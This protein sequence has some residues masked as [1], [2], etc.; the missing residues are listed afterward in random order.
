MHSCRSLR[1]QDNL[2]PLSRIMHMLTLV[3]PARR[4]AAF[5]LIELLVVIAIIAILAGMLLPALSKA[6]AKGQGILC[7]NNTRQL[8][9]AWQLYSGDFDDRVANNFGVNET[10]ASIQNGS[11]ANW[12][13][14]VMSWGVEQSVTNVN[15]VRN[16]VL[17]KYTAGA[18]GVYK[19]PADIYL[20]RNQK[21]AGF[22]SRLR[23]LSMNALFGLFSTSPSDPTRSGR[24]ALIPYKQY[25]KQ[26]DVRSPSEVWVTLDEHPNSI[27]DGYFIND[28]GITQWGDLPASYHNGAG[29]FSF[30]D[31]HAEIKKWKSG[32]TMIPVNPGGAYAARRFD[33]AG[34]KDFD[35]WRQRTGFINLQ[36][37]EMR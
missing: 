8:M 4:R 14:N 37:R 35:W 33:A 36:G 10:F 17:S 2:L 28:W 26:S 13:N 25:L 1:I 6:K 34:Q 7:M 32:T 20:S 18:L 31:G 24:N 27:N 30:A 22:T 15:W 16:G 29:G 5:T 11:F 9:Q 3:N 12:V 23:S 21:A 19:C